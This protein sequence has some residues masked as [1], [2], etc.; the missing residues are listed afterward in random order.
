MILTERQQ[1]PRKLN[2]AVAFDKDT[3][4]ADSCAMQIGCTWYCCVLGKNG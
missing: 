1:Q 3:D 4:I 2:F